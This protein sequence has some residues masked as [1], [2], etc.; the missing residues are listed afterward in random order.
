MNEYPKARHAFGVDPRRPEFYSLRQ[1]RYE[2]MAQDISEWAGQAARSGR[3]LSVLD[4]GCSNG[5]LSRYLE[6]K[7]NFEHIVLSGTEF[8]DRGLYKPEMY[9]EFFMGDLTAGHPE[10]RSDA[11]DVVVCEQVLEH[12]GQ[13]D[14]AMK[15]LER[16]LK[17]GGRLIV[18]V[19]IF[20]PPFPFFRNCLLKISRIFNPE[21]SWSHL[22]TFSYWS[23]LSRMRSVTKLRLIDTRGFRIIS[24]GV[25]R[26]WENHRWWWQF[27]CK[28]GKILPAACIEF[29][30]VM[31]K[32]EVSVSQ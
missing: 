8:V 24:G 20:L 32:S 5:T 9:H 4:V 25:L 21:K 23:F 22:Q 29:Q 16:V 1:A 17:P 13:L 15:T 11:Y 31:E 10:I 18:G 3:T 14:V 12:L 19:P 7:P 26:K 6:V 27:N 30:A 2:A 28:L